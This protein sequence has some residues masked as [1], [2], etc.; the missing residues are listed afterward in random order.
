MDPSVPDRS[1]RTGSFAKSA[2]KTI[3]SLLDFHPNAAAKTG[4]DIC[5]WIFGGFRNDSLPGCFYS[6][7]NRQQ[8]RCVKFAVSIKEG[9]SYRNI[10]P[11]NYLSLQK[12]LRFIQNITIGDFPVGC[13]QR[14]MLSFQTL[15]K[16]FHRPRDILTIHR[17][18]D[19]SSIFR[20][21]L[22]INRSDFAI[23]HLGQFFCNSQAVSASGKTINPNHLCSPRNCCIMA[24][25][26]ISSREKPNKCSIS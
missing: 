11:C 19:C 6:F 13:D 3:I 9:M 7:R 20:C 26:G 23:Q 25:S 16:S 12:F 21:G 2:V 1:N 17:E 8:L 10:C 24:H 15:Q 22:V 4:E 5:Q 18:N 14:D